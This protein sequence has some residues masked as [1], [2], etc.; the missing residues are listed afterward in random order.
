MCGISVIVALQNQ[1]HTIDKTPNGSLPSGVDGV[2]LREDHDA[3]KLAK[4]LDDSL[5][6]IEH[7]G[8]DSRGQWI[9][10]DKHIAF[11]HVRLAIN[12]LSPDGA[13]PFHDPDNT[14][15]AVVNGELYDHERIR[16][17]LVKTTGYKFKGRSDCEIVIALYKH[18]GISFL[19][20]LRGEFALCLYDE[21]TKFFIAARDRYGIKPLF[22]TVVEGR[23]LIAA[24]AKA[25]LP[26]GWKPEWDVKSI[27]DAGWNFDQR[28]IFQGV[29]K[30]RPGHY[31]TCASFGH[32]ETRQY[33]DVE[34]RDKHH[35]E[36]RTEQEM[37]AGVRDQMLK[38]IRLRLRADVPVGVYLSGGIDSSVIAGMVV[39]LVKEQGAHAGNDKELKRVNCFSIAFDED[40]GY[41]ESSIADRTAKWLDVKFHKKHMNEAAL[42]DRLD[43]AVWHCE[44][45]NPDLNFIGKFALS[46][47]PRENGFKVVLT[48]EGAD[49]NFG[50]YPMYL[51]DFLREPDHAWPQATL[52]DAERKHQCTKVEDETARYYASIGADASNRGENVASRQLNHIT[53]PAS[54]AAFQF[55]LFSPWTSCFGPADPRTCIANSVDGRVRDLITTKWHPLH[56]AEYVWTK[57][58]LANNFLSC[59]G[60]RTEMAHSIEA[61]TPFLDH[62]LTEYVNAL[63]PSMKIRWD[64]TTA[65]FKEKYVLRE[66][67]KPFVTQELY[68]RTK[69]PYSAPATWPADGPLHRKMAELVTEANVEA[70]GFVDW[71]GGADMLV[72]R[73]FGHGDALASRMCLVV[74]EWVV[75]GKRFGV[76]RAERPVGM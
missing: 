9:S 34:Y 70:L 50:G 72:E 59:L 25:F 2:N 12:D 5:N 26:L 19:S 46:E 13:Q 75:I 33:W 60:D 32:I 49:E 43:D 28:T 1:S 67:S 54:M 68:E 65:S 14:V 66:A 30:V 48:G 44:H 36:H 16:E 63:P 45:H 18:Y 27:R 23:L 69:H 17:E 24:E 57:G 47:V 42:A 73:A 40:S 38:S 31:L 21:K 39:H 15:H 52:S 41:D 6:L 37:I 58:H 76:K 56:S 53:T 10:K 3:A 11:G 22:W 74:A 55:N 8:P 35:I 51:P 64:P 29:N 4:E 7:R 61:R 20:Q 62:H 71:K